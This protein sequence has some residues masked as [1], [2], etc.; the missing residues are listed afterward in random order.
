MLRHQ[1]QPALRHRAA[2]DDR[3][4]RRPRSRR[5][6]SC[7]RR[8]SRPASRRSR[9]TKI[10]RPRIDLVHEKARRRLDQYRR[11]ARVAGRGVRHFVRPRLQLRSGELPPA[12]DQA[13]LGPGPHPGQRT[14]AT[15]VEERPRPRTLRRRRADPGGPGGPGNR[16]GRAHR[17]PAARGGRGE[18]VP[19]ELRPVQLTLA[20][21]SY[22]K[23]SLVRDYES[24]AR[25]GAGKSR[26][27]RG[28][29]LARAAAGRRRAAGGARRSPS[30]STWCLRPDAGDRRRRGAPRR[31]A[32]SSRGRPA[33]ASRRR[34][35]T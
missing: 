19:L 9:S 8:R 7:S 2:G 20:N 21:S 5:S 14:C 6:S 3:P 29:L 13:V 11:S 4:R 30:A 17:L 34:S 22:R 10:D 15:I 1:L 28:H 32:T 27:L 25:G 24:A 33:P 26:R 23:M 18:P 16:R 12:G 31:A 35:P